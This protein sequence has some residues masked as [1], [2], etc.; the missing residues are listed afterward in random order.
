MES[1]FP[2]KKFSR[3]HLLGAFI[4]MRECSQDESIRNSNPHSKY[5]H[6]L[7]IIDNSVNSIFLIFSKY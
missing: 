5:K 6:I 1:I 4:T 2:I 3:I 7:Y